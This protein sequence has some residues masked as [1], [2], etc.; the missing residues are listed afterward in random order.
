MKGH[1]DAVQDITFDH[2][3]KLLGMRKEKIWRKKILILIFFF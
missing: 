2:T 3:G 1:T